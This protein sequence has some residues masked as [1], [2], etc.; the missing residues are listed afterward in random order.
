MSTA[1][2]SERSAAQPSNSLL[3]NFRQELSRHAPFSQ[4]N[5][6]DVDFFSHMPAKPILRLM[7]SCL[8]PAVASPHICITFA[9][10]R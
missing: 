10:A 6:A 5:A 9:K 3:A 2:V 1:P 8:T 7:K 4:M